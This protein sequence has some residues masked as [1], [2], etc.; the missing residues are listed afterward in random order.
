[1]AMEKQSRQ[2]PPSS[3]AVNSADDEETN[4]N[5]DESISNDGTAEVEVEA[6]AVQ[7]DDIT[8]TAPDDNDNN[9]TK[10]R[11]RVCEICANE[12]A[13]SRY[14]IDGNGISEEVIAQME[15]LEE[16]LETGIHSEDG[17]KLT[18]R[19]IKGV[20]RQLEKLRLDA[21]GKGKKKDVDGEE[22]E[23]ADEGEEEEGDNDED[24]ESSN[25]EE[26]VDENGG[27]DANEIDN[28]DDA[29]DPFLLAIGGKDKLLVGEE[30]QKMLL[31]REQSKK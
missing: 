30:Y 13:L 3:A 24:D 26:S 20:E 21:T 29:N 4:D 6:E 25:N 5:K 19:E 11:I 31:A 9:K 1:M 16:V 7:E 23:E 28:D 8:N 18:L 15:E 2:P 10:R 17:H 14:T 12:P 27:N 22:E